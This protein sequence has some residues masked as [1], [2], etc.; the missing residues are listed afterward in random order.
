MGAA[1]A[2][3]LGQRQPLFLIL[4]LGSGAENPAEESDRHQ[5]I[6]SMQKGWKNAEYFRKK[7]QAQIHQL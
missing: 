3:S 2:T 1:P 5:A 4:P 6:S 7:A